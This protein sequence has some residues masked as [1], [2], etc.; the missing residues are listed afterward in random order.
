MQIVCD[1]CGTEFRLKQQSATKRFRCKFCGHVISVEGATDSTRSKSAPPVVRRQRG[2]RSRK[3]R[4][5]R[6][7]TLTRK[8]LLMIVVGVLTA[9][10]IVLLVSLARNG[11][12]QSAWTTI[13][14]TVDNSH[15]QLAADDAAVAAKYADILESVTDIETAR[16]AVP[17]IEG[18]VKEIDALA[19]RSEQLGFPPNYEVYK[20]RAAAHLNRKVNEG[21][22]IQGQLDR[23]VSDRQ[24]V[25]I[26]EPVLEKVNAAGGRFATAGTPK[27]SEAKRKEIEEEQRKTIAAFEE[28]SKREEER[29]KIEAERRKKDWERFK[30]KKPK[31]PADMFLPFAERVERFKSKHGVENVVSVEITQVGNEDTANLRMQLYAAA[32]NVRYSMSTSSSKEDKAIFVLAGVKDVQEFADRIQFGMVT[33]VDPES[34]VIYMRCGS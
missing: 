31:L 6:S 23:L 21:N 15:V 5:K 7:R 24:I 29:W 18:I 17:S 3:S 14:E 19:A 8:Q 33:K 22:R 32:G 12:L 13:K 11:K 9:S 28:E 2:G 30:S 34:R 16:K 26:L 25:Q 4:P 10:C 1:K 27:M 20:L